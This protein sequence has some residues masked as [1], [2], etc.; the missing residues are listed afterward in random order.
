MGWRSKM[1]L[2]QLC[3][4]GRV[5]SIFPGTQ[6]R[7]KHLQVIISG[8][9]WQAGTC[10]RSPT[11]SQGTGLLAWPW[12]SSSLKECNMDQPQ[13]HACL[14]QCL[15]VDCS[16]Q[17]NYRALSACETPHFFRN[18][19]WGW[20]SSCMCVRARSIQT[21]HVREGREKTEHRITPSPPPFGLCYGHGSLCVSVGEWVRETMLSRTDRAPQQRWGW[22]ER[23]KR[24]GL[25][26]IHVSD[27]SVCP[28][29]SNS[30]WEDPLGHADTPFLRP[31]TL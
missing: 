18:T 24:R 4:I 7:V 22:K 8:K 30:V 16:V 5:R 17:I 19:I 26:C 21:D 14:T 31:Q 13:H 23:L 15:H 29:P 6:T 11:K 20:R 10:F 12:V 27:V 3:T 1:H 2:F 28:F 9:H 25:G